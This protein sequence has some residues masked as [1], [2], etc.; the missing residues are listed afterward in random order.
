MRLL[1]WKVRLKI[2]ILSLSF[3]SLNGC[4]S[5]LGHTVSNQIKLMSRRVPIEMALEIYDFNEDEKE[6]LKM[7]S[8][9]KTFARIKLGMDINKNV[10]STY[11][12]LN[13]PYVT[14]LLRVSEIYA[15]K[16]YTWYF[17]VVGKVPY[18]GFFDKELAKGEAKTFPARKYDTIVRGVAAY[19][20]LGWTEDSVLSSM[21]PYSKGDFTITVFHELAHTV[22]FFSSQINFNERFAE[23]VGRKAAELFFQAKEGESSETLQMMQ[24]Q[25]ADELIFFAFMEKEYNLLDQWYKNNIGRVTNESKNRR[26]KE[27]QNRF[28]LQIQ[29]Q[30]KTHRYDYFPKIRLN[31]AQMLS[32]R[33]YNYKMDEF[34]KLYDLSGHDMKAFIQLCSRFEDDKNPE[35]ALSRF[36]NQSSL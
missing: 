32:Y 5:Y 10:Y 8:E 25:W 28:L 11:I 7:V 18:K 36:V 29:P 17:P 35:E 15:L 3:F 2:F 21:L 1:H 4:L 30:M 34:E 13:R 23:F 9:I 27:I 14:Y 16:P 19:S 12:Q 24:A 20:T 26:L 22:L 31:N 6:K 33:T